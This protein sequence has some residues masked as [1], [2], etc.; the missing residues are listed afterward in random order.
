MD[1][2]NASYNGLFNFATREYLFLGVGAAS[3]GSCGAIGLTR[4]YGKLTNLTSSFQNIIAGQAG[5]MLI[6]GC[7][8][9]AISGSLDFSYT[10]VAIP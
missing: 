10:G 1:K 7:N 4:V 6:L 8:P 2:G 9:V 5:S 3:N